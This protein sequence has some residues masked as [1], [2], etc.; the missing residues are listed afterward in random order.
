MRMFRLIYYWLS[1]LRH[2]SKLRMYFR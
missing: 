1:V 2:H